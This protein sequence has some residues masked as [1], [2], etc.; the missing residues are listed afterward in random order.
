MQTIYLVRHGAYENPRNILHGRLPVELS[1]E[2]TKQANKLKEYFKYKDI[3]K[4][5]SSAVLRCKRTSEIISD[6]KIPIIHDKRILEVLSAYQGYWEIDWTQFFSHMDEL[7]GESYKDVQKR[8]IDFW[9]EIYKKEPGNFIICS[10]G[11]PLYLLMHY[12]INKPIPKESEPQSALPDYPKQGS[13]I[14]VI[15]KPDGEFDF[16]FRSELD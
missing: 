2:G 15:K 12:L 7:G 9:N 1:E 11:D 4:I 3:S 8:M 5:Y 6:N 10:H 13:A 14:E 16:V